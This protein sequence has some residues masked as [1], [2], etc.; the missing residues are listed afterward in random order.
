MSVCLAAGQIETHDLSSSCESEPWE[1]VS[2]LID[3]KGEK[4][5]LTRD[6]VRPGRLSEKE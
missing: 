5:R 2:Y 1:S 3:G 6:P 4:L